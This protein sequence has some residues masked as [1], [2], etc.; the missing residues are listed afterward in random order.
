M[1]K[2]TKNAGEKMTKEGILGKCVVGLFLPKGLLLGFCQ[3]HDVILVYFLYIR[4]CGCLCDLL[5]V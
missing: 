3:K 2:M 1:S 5:H 4:Q